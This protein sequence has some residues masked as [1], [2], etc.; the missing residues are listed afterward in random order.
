MQ[1]VISIPCVQYGNTVQ[2]NREVYVP[3]QA[4]CEKGLALHRAINGKGY[5]LTHIKSGLPVA[6]VQASKQKCLQWLHESAG[7]LDFTVEDV[8]VAQ[9]VDTLKRII[10]AGHTL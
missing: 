2:E 5:T 7:L 1:A 10:N 6:T 4:T 3:V 8:F 9:Y